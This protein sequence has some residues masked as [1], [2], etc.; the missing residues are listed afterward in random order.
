MFKNIKKDSTKNLINLENKKKSN[1]PS[2]FGLYV[3]VFFFL[4]SKFNKIS[5]DRFLISFSTIFI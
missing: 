5:R 3:L 2:A 1:N 4:V